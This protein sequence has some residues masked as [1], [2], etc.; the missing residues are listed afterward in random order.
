V[1]RAIARGDEKAAATASDKLLDYIES[2]T[3]SRQM[4]A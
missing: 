2:F 3:R 1:A 4:P